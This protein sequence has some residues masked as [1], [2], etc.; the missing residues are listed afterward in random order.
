MTFEHLIY[1]ILYWYIS[2]VDRKKEIIFMNYGYHNEDD[3]IIL[4]SKDEIN[5]YSIQL[6]HKLAKMVD[7]SDKNIVEVGCGRGGGLDY[8]TR[9]FKPAT[10]L[11]IDLDAKA[12]KFGNKNFDYKGL[13]FNHGDAQHLALKNESIDIVFNVESSHRYPNM[14]LFLNEV[15]RTLNPGGYFLFTDFRPKNK[16]NELKLLLTKYSFNS[17][18]EKIINKEVIK[19]LEL[20]TPRR[21]ALVKKHIPFFFHKLIHDFAGNIGSPTFNKIKEGEIIYFIYCF[22]KP[23]I[24]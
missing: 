3:K 21:T 10:A 5:R 14:E 18:H 6:Y 13:N 16:M 9:K 19:A 8:I 4:Q 1:K 15:Y 7:L 17:I 24:R 2:T 23:L 11:G 22:Q 20:D 12:V